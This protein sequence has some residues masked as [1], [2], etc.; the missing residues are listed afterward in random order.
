MYSRNIYIYI[1][2]VGLFTIGCE[3]LSNDPGSSGEDLKSDKGLN[4]WGGSYNDFGH[5]VVQTA[6]GGYGVVGS[7]YSS[8]DQED[9]ILVKFSSSL[10]FESNTIY[11]GGIDSTYSNIANDLQ[12]T[13]DGGYITVGSTFNGT[14]YDVWV[15]KFAS[16]LTTA[17]EDTIG[18]AGS[19][20]FGSSIQQLN[21]GAYV[22]CGTSY[23]A[24]NGDYDIMVWTVSY[25]A[26]TDAKTDTTI[27]ADTGSGTTNTTNDFGS[28]AHQTE[29]GGFIV[30]GTQGS[31][32]A[33]IKLL[34]DGS[35][36]ADR[37]SDG[38]AGSSTEALCCTENGGTFANSTCTDGTE[39][40]ITGFSGD[41][42]LQ[43]DTGNNDEGTFV[44][45]LSDGSYIVVGNT[46]A[47]TGQQSNIYINTVSSIGVVGTTAI[48]MGGAYDDKVE[49]VR[50]T[51]DGG[52][53]FTGG[54]YD[55]A[56]GYDVWVVKLTP[57]LTTHWDYT[58]GGD[59]NDHGTSINQTDDGGYIITGSTMSYGNQSEII[60][61]KL[62]NTGE[63]DDL[64]GQLK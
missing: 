14:D 55:D 31:N 16:D 37:C 52:F 45:E 30:V 64:I 2:I 6:D 21:S 50:Q 13:S 62:N 38:A 33:L 32:I 36:D 25:N 28:H 46:E 5:A 53:V 35:A 10:K 19:D 12:Q 15:I 54:K 48:T 17:W 39:T 57:T 47:G 43:V 60:L 18:T 11:G 24:T 29:D 44:Q 59:L 8:D 26:T 23:D 42:F 34:A 63:I 56:T 27:F 3:K 41:G 49:C 61:L 20:D 1:L 58:F 4:Y 51:S 7:Q 9:L 40:W 22:V